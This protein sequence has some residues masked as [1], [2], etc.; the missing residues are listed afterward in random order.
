MKYERLYTILDDIEIEIMDTKKYP[1]PPQPVFEQLWDLLTEDI[2]GRTYPLEAEVPYTTMEK[3][4]PIL[5]WY[6]QSLEKIV[7]E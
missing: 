1:F 2:R 3:V 6:H 4:K 7:K 5:E